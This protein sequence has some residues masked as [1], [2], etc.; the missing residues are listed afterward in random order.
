VRVGDEVA[1]SSESMRFETQLAEAARL[2]GADRI[3]ATLAA[4]AIFDRGEYLPGGRS[5]WA[6]GRQQELADLA[7][8]ARYEAAE[9]ALAAGDYSQAQSLSAAVL[10]ADPFREAAWRLVMRIADALGDEKSVVRAY[11]DC[12]RSL[13]EL[14]TTPSPT[15][16]QLLERLRR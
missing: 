2:Q 3:A 12:E 1:I 5:D 6:D 15:T 16:R 7:T 9:L 4:L 8:D 13:G 14:G 10:V 11:H